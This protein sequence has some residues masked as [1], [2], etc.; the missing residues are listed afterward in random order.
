M[1]NY[2]RTAVENM[3]FLGMATSSIKK[4]EQPSFNQQVLLSQEQKYNFNRKN[5]NRIQF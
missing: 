4:Q 1:L 3:Q 5:I 2:S